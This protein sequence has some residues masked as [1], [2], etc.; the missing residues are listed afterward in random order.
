[1]LLGSITS[2]S[3]FTSNILF[4]CSLSDNKYAA[5]IIRITNNRL[6]YYIVILF[7]YYYISYFH[8]IGI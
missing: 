2:A 1:M 4:L 7:I 8:V 5:G 6:K 3:P